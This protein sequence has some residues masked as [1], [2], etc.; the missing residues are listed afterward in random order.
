MNQI[1]QFSVL[2]A[3]CATVVLAAAATL[4]VWALTGEAHSTPTL[5]KG[6][7]LDIQSRGVHCSQQAW[8][9]YDQGCLRST[10][11]NVPQPVRVVVA[12]RKS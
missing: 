5:G 3:A 7:R 12:Q 2:R 10:M 11:T 1:S 8:P 4:T 6:D 9:Y